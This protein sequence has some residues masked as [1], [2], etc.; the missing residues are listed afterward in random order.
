MDMR[1]ASSTYLTSIGAGVGV[2]VRVRLLRISHFRHFSVLFLSE[3]EAMT[4]IEIW[5]FEG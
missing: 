4:G 5:W 1:E 3:L 2:E